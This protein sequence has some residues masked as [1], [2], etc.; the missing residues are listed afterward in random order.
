MRIPIAIRSTLEEPEDLRAALA[1]LA[2]LD[3][4]QVDRGIVPPL[5]RS[6]VRYGRE[7][8][9]AGVAEDWQTSART[10]ARGWGDCED[11]ACW[12]AAEV[13]GAVPWPVR[14]PAGWHIVVR[15][16]D[17]SVEDP[18]ARLG[19]RLPRGWS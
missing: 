14:T 17:G 7:R 3:R 4:V 19:M 15:M 9:V 2:A 16:P 8:M 12:R 1:A 6:G 11:L 18:S 13:A 10:L 5:Y